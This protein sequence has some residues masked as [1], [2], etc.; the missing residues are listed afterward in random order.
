VCSTVLWSA[1][2]VDQTA[3]G[4]LLRELSRAEPTRVEAFVRRHARFMS[5]ECIHQ[6]VENLTAA[7][8]RDLNRALEA[9]DDAHARLTTG[10]AA[11]RTR[12]AR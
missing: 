5:R 11:R 6:A 10:A 8:Q 2:R 1:E 7:R 3:V 9:R 4:W 12:P